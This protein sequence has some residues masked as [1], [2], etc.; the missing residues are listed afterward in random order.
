MAQ[1]TQRN[2]DDYSWMVPI[3]VM[4]GSIGHREVQACSI[5]RVPHKLR[6][7]ND[8]PYKPK[9]VALG[10]LHR[11][12]RS[13]LLQMEEPKWQ[14]M[15]FLL[16]RAGNQNQT[17][18]SEVRLKDCGS[19][20]LALDN[21]VRASYGGN[22]ELEPHELAK[23]ML[24]DGCFVLEL[25][26]RLHEYM[27]TQNPKDGNYSDD[28]ILES[29]EK[30]LSV[31]TD[32]TLLENQIPFIVLKKLYRKIF[33]MNIEV[34]DDH[35]V[36]EL[37]L[38][39]FGYPLVQS[40]NVAHLLHLMHS[41]I[42]P[43][44]SNQVKQARQELKRCATMLR[45]AG[46]TIGPANSTN[47]NTRRKFVDTFEFNINLNDGSLEIAPL[48][49]RETTEVNWRN[50]I[51][52]EQSRIGIR[53]KFTSYALLFQGLVCCEHDIKLLEQNKV[54]TNE[55]KKSRE[56]LLKLFHTIT[57]GVDHMDSSYSELC[58]SLNKYSSA[59]PL[60]KWPIITWHH[61]NRILAIIQF[62]WENWYQILVRD[63]IPT[64]WKLIGVLAAAV[65]LALTI[66]Q[67]YYAAR[68]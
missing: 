12:T 58:M 2:A 50:F 30:L 25:L 35:R 40:P 51:A 17:R 48:H 11:G 8:D 59:N 44:E 20:I 22:I 38:N 36:A 39:A 9:A 29:E 26:L 16:R 5:C 33:P 68:S 60:K 63:H 42:I 56:D 47:V 18:R 3:E 4:L 10:P 28:P 55:A 62:Y 27:A 54:I 31:L 64:V 52:W 41:S 23:I 14:Y 21:V 24:V 45:A 46:I 53:C 6:K 61:W 37:V 57:E 32:L 1:R 34:E 67:T 7:Q 65:L 15:R 43:K 13:D 49:V 19:A 66:V